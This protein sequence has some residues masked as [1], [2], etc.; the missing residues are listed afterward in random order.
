MLVSAGYNPLVDLSKVKNPGYTG[1]ALIVPDKFAQKYPNTTLALTA[2]YLEGLTDFLQG[3]QAKSAATWAKYSEEP[4]KQATD[5]VK[6]ELSTKW[7]P[8]DGRCNNATFAFEKSVLVGT[9]PAIKK[10]DPASVCTDQF[11][12]KLKQL[13]WQKAIGV[14]GY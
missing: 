9:N 1:L 5:D 4:L 7:T 3:P 6:T 12:D 11:L 13:G 10:V 8:V 14:Q 2:M